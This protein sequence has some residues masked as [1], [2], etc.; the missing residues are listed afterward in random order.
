M[1][2]DDGPYW[3]IGIAQPPHEWKVCEEIR[4]GGVDLYLPIEL[5]QQRA[6]RGKLRDV[7]QPILRPYFFVPATIT[8]DQYIWVK[9]TPGVRGFLEVGGKPAFMRDSELKRVRYQ[10]MT[11]D[12]ARRRRDIERGKGPLFI[13][14]EAVEI[15]VGFAN[16]RGSVHSVGLAR[17][18]VQLETGVTLFGRS[19][20][21]VDLA[22]L[23]PAM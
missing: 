19:V 20:V 7:V 12:Q 5:K 13:V 15:A 22:H 17:A 14:G 18:E 3:L 23:S 8:D 11:R 1:A 6:G 2:F 4:A 21:E 16:L 10:E 9:H